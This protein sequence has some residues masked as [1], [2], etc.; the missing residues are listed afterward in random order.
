RTGLRRRGIADPD[1]RRLRIAAHT[2]RLFLDTHGATAPSVAAWQHQ[3]E[4]H[5]GEA[6][7]DGAS[8]RQNLARRAVDQGGGPNRMHSRPATTRVSGPL[9]KE[10]PDLSARTELLLPG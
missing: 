5:R 8:Q 10:L 2:A 7:R 6:S 4:R 1:H 9:L 3:Q